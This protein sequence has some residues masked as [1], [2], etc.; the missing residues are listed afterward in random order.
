[1]RHLLLFC[2]ILLATGAADLRAQSCSPSYPLRYFNP[3]GSVFVYTQNL[4]TVWWAVRMTPQYAA[5]IDS[6]YISFGVQKNNTP[7]LMDSLEVR[8]LDNTLPTFTQLD[9]LKAA[10]PPNIGGQVPDNYWIVELDFDGLTARLNPPRDFWLAWRIKGPS[11]DVARIIMKN[12]SANFARSVVI[13]PNGTTKDVSLYLLTTSFRDTVDLWA[14]TRVCYYNGTPVELVSLTAREANGSA[15]LEWSTATETN[16]FGFEVQRVDGRA[17]DG[18]ITFWR[19]IGFVNGHGTTAQPRRYT[20][21]DPTPRE[22]SDEGGIVRYRLR[23]IDYDG[24]V[25][26]SPVCELRLAGTAA[27]VD[28]AANYPNPVTGGSTAISFGLSVA[29]NARLE[30]RDALGRI[31]ASTP[32]CMYEPGRHTVS[33][34]LNALSSGTYTYTLTAGAVRLAKSLTIMR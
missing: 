11:V 33:L 5:E 16:N 26:Q 6:A 29:R 25:N 14:E 15:L 8:I 4:P 12:P 21:I 30:V 2:A 32:E 19:K 1:M 23:Q 31:V 3:G 9:Y 24:T 20:F 17:A 27:G 28:L 22:A 18:R 34:D 10:V 13:Y 7:L